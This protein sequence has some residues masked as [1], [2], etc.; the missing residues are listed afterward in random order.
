[1]TQQTK[2]VE[3]SVIKVC[4]KESE[5]FKC[6]SC[7]KNICQHS[8]K[9]WTCKIHNCDTCLE[10]DYDYDL[11]CKICLKTCMQNMKTSKS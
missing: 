3:S 1:M 5:K 7:E 10:Y 4:C 2:E 9:C 11:F 6:H 8:K